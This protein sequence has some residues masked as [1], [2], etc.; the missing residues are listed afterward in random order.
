MKKFTTDKEPTGDLL[1][2]GPQVFTSYFNR[3]EETKKS[4]TE[5]GWFMT[6]E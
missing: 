5:D 2:K 6:G 3:P 1:I 4:F